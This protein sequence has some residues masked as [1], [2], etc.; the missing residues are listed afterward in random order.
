MVTRYSVRQLNVAE[1]TIRGYECDV[2][3]FTEQQFSKAC[4]LFDLSSEQLK[5]R[6]RERKGSI[7][8]TD[9]VTS[10]TMSPLGLVGISKVIGAVIPTPKVGIA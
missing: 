6:T 8:S 10:Q 1:K 2:A 3:L 7:P 4:E 9:P 5:Q